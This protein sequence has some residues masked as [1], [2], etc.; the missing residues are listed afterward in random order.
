MPS[1][2]NSWSDL[3]QAPTLRHRRDI[4]LVAIAVGAIAGASVIFFP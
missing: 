2:G 1:I 3:G 4:A